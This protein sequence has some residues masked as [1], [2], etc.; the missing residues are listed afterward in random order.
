MGPLELLA[1]Q[2]EGNRFT[3]EIIPELRNVL[4]KGVIRMIDLVFVRKEID[5][6]FAVTEVSELTDD[7]AAQYGN[8]INDMQGL[9]TPEDIEI[10]VE[11][12]PDRSSVAVLLFEHAWAEGLKDTVA[13]AGGEVVMR[14]SI[15]QATLDILSEELVGAKSSRTE[16]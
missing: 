10:V 2:F 9:L 6:E 13:R 14:E 1:I 16:G 8:V 5:G 15:P 4:D 7:E 12:L 11:T 3:G